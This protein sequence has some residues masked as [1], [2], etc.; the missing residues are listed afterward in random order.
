M[1]RVLRLL[2]LV[3]LCLVAV[4]PL[5]AEPVRLIYDTDFQSDCDDAGALAMLHSLADRGEVELLAVITSATGPKIAPAIS[6]FNLFYHRRAIPI[7]DMKY[8]PEQF[9]RSSDRYTATIAAEFP[10]DLAGEDDAP[11]AV[12][13]YREILSSRPDHSVVLLTVGFTRNIA[14]LL[15]SGPDQFSPD[16]GIELVRRKVARYVTMGGEFSHDTPEAPTRDRFNWKHDIKD[17]YAAIREILD[18]WPSEVPLISSGWTVGDE[19]AFDPAFKSVWAGEGTR[20][21]PQD[22]ILR[23][24]YELWFQGKDNWNRHCNDQCATLYAVRG[25]GQDFIEHLH[26][27]I[28]V[29]PDG[30]DTW[31][32]DHD[33]NQGY[34]AKA[35]D[36]ALISAEIEQLMLHDPAPADTT[37]PTP[38]GTVTIETLTDHPRSFRLS[39]SPGADEDVGSW[40]A[41]YHVYRDG[42]LVGIAAG[43]QYFDQPPK[44]SRLRYEVAAV[45]AAGLESMR[46]T[47]VVRITSTTAP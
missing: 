35:R 32:T 24:T 3:L 10:H 17:P 27:D 4:S 19:G 8:T 28:D 15:A 22:H 42:L 46:A 26:G 18:A 1:T 6:A 13:L 14:D 2:L 7:G 11:S 20:N 45:N 40:V 29:A 23:R 33:L 31:S 12:A 44:R 5:S 38:P 36:A 37:P 43:T 47:T 34:I 16:T 25:P 39:W 9:S 21:L 41:A 30:A